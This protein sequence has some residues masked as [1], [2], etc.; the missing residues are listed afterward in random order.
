MKISPS[1]YLMPRLLRISCVV[2]ALPTLQGQSSAPEQPPI[3]FRH[4]NVSDLRGLLNVFDAFR[5]ACLAQPVSR[6]LPERLMPQ[7]YKN[8]TP[9]FHLW[10]EE[11][12]KPIDG[13]ILSKT[14]TEEGDFADGT[15]FIDFRMPSE[16]SPDGACRVVWQREWDY[17][18]E[19]VDDVM[20]G[21]AAT[22][23]AQ[24]SFRLKAILVSPPDGVFVRSR[25]Y[26][27]VSNWITRCW[28]G[29]FCGFE[30]LGMLGK[31]DI[32]ITIT[33]RDVLSEPADGGI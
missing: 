28:G 18:Q 19:Q 21:T 31:D 13:A 20:F 30:V 32:H 33:R 11:I 22:F 5:V 25:Q 4:E 24:V 3:V 1:R 26:G 29:N 10:G 2:L 14:G 17:P 23:D 15:P 7:N 9:S 12:G 16:S 8:V 27:M 6:D